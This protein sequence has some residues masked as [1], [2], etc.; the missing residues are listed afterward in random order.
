MSLNPQLRGHPVRGVANWRES[1]VPISIHGDTVPVT[2]VGKRWTKAADVYSWASLVAHGPTRATNIYIYSIF[3]RL[4]STFFGMSTKSKFW[5]IMSWSFT[6]L[7]RGRFP[8]EDAWGKRYTSGIDLERAGKALTS[9]SDFYCGI[10]WT[11]RADLD[12]WGAEFLL[13]RHNSGAAPCPFCP[14]KPGPGDFINA[15]LRQAQYPCDSV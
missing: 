13:P 9:E 4:I 15:D 12:F 3:Q 10:L 14:A 2:G 6:A 1:A 7:Q 8:A 5:K 11:V